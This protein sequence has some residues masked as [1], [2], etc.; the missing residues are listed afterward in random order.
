MIFDILELPITMSEVLSLLEESHPCPP[1]TSDRFHSI[2]HQLPTNQKIFVYSNGGLTLGIGSFMVEQ[3]LT[4]G[5]G[6]VA[7]ITDLVVNDEAPAGAAEE[8]LLR[9]IEESRGRGC[10]RAVSPIRDKYKSSFKG[11]GFTVLQ[12]HHVLVIHQ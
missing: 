6:K 4:H 7:H 2:I 9:I 1:I 12:N 3:R 10:C 5:G 8:L 11:L